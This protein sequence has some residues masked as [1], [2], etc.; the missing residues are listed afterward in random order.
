MGATNKLNIRKLLNSFGF[1]MQGIADLIR[2]EQNARIH[3]FVSFWVVIAG[4][5]TGLS[6][7]EWCLIAL[8]IGL[9]FSA[10][11][12]N[13]VVEKLVDHLFPDKHETARFAKDV[14]AG[15][16][17]LCAIMAVVCGLLIFIPKWWVLIQ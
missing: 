8:C 9:V 5:L 10:E 11:A 6:S 4:L 16:V 12:F 1:A 17:L 3:L 15:G 14:A 2:S 13:T 7:T